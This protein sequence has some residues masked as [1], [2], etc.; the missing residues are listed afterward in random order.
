MRRINCRKIIDTVSD[1]IQDACIDL[2][3]DVVTAL[4]KARKTEK[5]SL[6]RDVLDTIMSNIQIASAKRLPLCQ[7]TGTAVIFLELGQEVHITGG[8][9]Y[10]AVDRGVKKGYAEGFL[11]KSMV[12]LPF[13]ARENTGDNT[14]AV[15]HTDI[16]SGDKL[17]I[18]AL[19]KG[20][21][22]ENCSRLMVFPPSGGQKAIIEY[23]SDLIDTCGC[24][25]CPPLIVG[26]GIGGTTEKTMLLAK[27]ALLRPVGV[28]SIRPEV[29]R[30]EKQILKV[31]NKSG[32]GPM[33]YG[34][35]ITALAV[36]I[37]TFPAHI[38]SMPVAVNLQCW[39]SRHREVVL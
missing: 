15:I 22:A 10:Q 31:I 30:L 14:P 21:G 25:A 26:I 3:E 2:P 27:R 36:H 4:I 37:E 19:P 16:V 12:S 38:A 28:P 35:S 29:A 1:L 13:T 33:G 18:I 6:G 8:D 23:V 11:R 20:G 5:S 9:L 17:K 32:I 34:G 24:N 39:C 7:D